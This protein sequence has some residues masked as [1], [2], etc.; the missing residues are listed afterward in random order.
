M[1]LKDLQI[2]RELKR[3]LS[4][5]VPIISF[6]VFGSRARGDADEYSDLDV[7]IEVQSL[8]RALKDKMADIVWEVGFENYLVISSLIVTKDEMDNSPLRSSSIIGRISEEGINV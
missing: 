7:F 8:D 1:T 5:I 6:K 3:R 4:E 2:V